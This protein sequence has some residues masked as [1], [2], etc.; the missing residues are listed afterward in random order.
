MLKVERTHLPWISPT[1]F[2]LERYASL[3]VT[4]FPCLRDLNSITAILWAGIFRSLQSTEGA[5]GPVQGIGFFVVAMVSPVVGVMGDK[6]KRVRIMAF[7]AVVWSVLV[8]CTS[9][10]RS[11]GLFLVMWQLV[12]VSNTPLKLLPL[13]LLADYIPNELCCCLLVCSLTD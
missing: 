10:I 7:A 13:A 4:R 2:C 1:R 5:L 6:F 3:C 11:Y 8:F 12:V 9:F